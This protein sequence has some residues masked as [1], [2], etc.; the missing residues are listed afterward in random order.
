M[1]LIPKDRL[2]CYEFE[3][4]HKSMWDRNGL[5]AYE[6]N[7]K[8]K[9]V[10]VCVGTIAKYVMRCSSLAILVYTINQRT[11][12]HHEPIPLIVRR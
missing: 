5:N 9:R 11:A 10:F 1:L 8:T 4:F 7:I 6:L 3:M 12:A 2:S